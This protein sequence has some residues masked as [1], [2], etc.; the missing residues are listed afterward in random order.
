[1]E[2]RM[3]KRKKNPGNSRRRR[4]RNQPGKF[5]SQRVDKR[6]QRRDGQHSWPVLR[7][8]GKFLRMRKFKRG[9][10]S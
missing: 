4:R 6:R 10:V 7:V 9:V 8:V 1:M 2:R 3:T 5:R